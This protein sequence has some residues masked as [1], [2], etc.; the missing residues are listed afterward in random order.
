MTELPL[1][2]FNRRLLNPLVRSFAGRLPGLATVHHTGRRS[3]QAFATPVRVCGDRGAF[4]VMVANGRTPDWLRNLEAAGGGALLVA[5]ARRH[6]P[7][8]TR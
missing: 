1:A 7:A 8:P 6:R 3:G 2:G 5:G 4:Y